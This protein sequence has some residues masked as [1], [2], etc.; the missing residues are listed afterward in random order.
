VT[1]VS[2]YTGVLVALIGSV[3]VIV[4]SRVVAGLDER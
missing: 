3:P 1:I 4:L 2:I